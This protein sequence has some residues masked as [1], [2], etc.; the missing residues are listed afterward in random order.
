MSD[1]RVNRLPDPGPVGRQDTS[2]AGI[3]EER[4]RFEV[5]LG[6]YLVD[7]PASLEVSRRMIVACNRYLIARARRRSG[8]FQRHAQYSSQIAS[9]LRP[10]PYPFAGRLRNRTDAYRVLNGEGNVRELQGTIWL[11]FAHI[12]AEDLVGPACRADVLDVVA[13]AGLSPSAT[14]EWLM[15]ARVHAAEGGRDVSDA[16][17]HPYHDLIQLPWHPIRQLQLESREFYS[18]LHERGRYWSHA[19]RSAF[20]REGGRFSDIERVLTSPV[21]A[22]RVPWIDPA[23]F[24][25]PNRQSPFVQDAWQQQIPLVTGLSGGAM[26]VH[27]FARV[28]D[29][30]TDDSLLAAT[31]GYLISSGAHSFYEVL[32]GYGDNTTRTHPGPG[33]SQIATGPF[34]DL[35]MIFSDLPN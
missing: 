27:L 30:P 22:D 4:R 18:P 20:C 32:M 14:Q 26:T 35:P 5:R 1:A 13:A 17:L 23:R 7:H 19:T 2:T 24:I 16:A 9:M 33:Y 3:L 21:G 6:H 8:Q 31:I 29:I 10:V 15:N 28:L 25:R 12:L 11:F 34:A